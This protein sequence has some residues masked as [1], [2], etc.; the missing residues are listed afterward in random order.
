MPGLIFLIWKYTYFGYFLPNSFYLKVSGNESVLNGIRYVYGYFN[1]AGFLILSVGLIGLAYTDIENRKHFSKSL[2][3]SILLV[4]PL[5]LLWVI[6]TVS[7]PLMG[8][9]S[10]FI[11]PAHIALLTISISLIVN[12]LGE[13]QV[14]SRFLL[15]GVLGVVVAMPALKMLTKDI[16]NPRYDPLTA[17]EESVG[18]ALKEMPHHR[19]ITIF[20]GDCGRIPYY[21]ESI[22]IDRVGLNDNFIARRSV[23]KE[24]IIDYV[25]DQQPDLVSL[26][27]NPDGTWFSQHHGRI[28]HANEDLYRRAV[29]EGYEFTAGFDAGWV[30]ILWFGRVDSLYAEEITEGLRSIADYTTYE[31]VHSGDSQW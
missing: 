31:V 18:Q 12:M 5:F 29:Q 27:A 21:S 23:S 3:K 16:V 1:S 2:L 6:Y 11:Y 24:V 20:L 10:R 25:F 9:F 4:S 7:N 8:T 22:V 15:I 13:A 14:L 28:G 30:H 17:V 19:D 26:W